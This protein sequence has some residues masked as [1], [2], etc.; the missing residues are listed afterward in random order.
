MTYATYGVMQSSDFNDR[1]NT[2]NGYWGTGSGN[3]GYG[4]SE[5][6]SV[7]PNG[8]L[9]ATSFWNSLVT[10]MSTVASHQGTTLSSMLPVPTSQSTILFL[11]NIDTNQT[12]LN[13]NRLNAAAQASTV[14]STATSTSTWS[15]SMTVT[16]TVTFASQNAVRYYF[17]AG[18][19]I[20][21][22]FSHPNTTGINTL[23]SDLC[24]EAGTVWISSPVSGT[25]SL[26]SVNYN[27]VTKVG[28]VTS[29]RSTVNTNYGFYAFTGTST[30]IFNQL[31]DAG[32]IAYQ[33]GTFLRISASSNGS[34]ILT[35]ACLFDEVPNGLAVST[36]TESTLTRRP[37]SATF[38][39]N[40]W[41]T[42]TVSSSISYL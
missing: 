39:S 8:V 3:A 15:N 25:V 38:L 42:P 17:N 28:G 24:S 7:S 35:F 11:S 10:N 2:F 20:G 13:N 16:F 23:V 33:A 6:G 22:S 9:T 5:L 31:S 29:A 34:G 18:G 1:R 27:G 12:T 14:A 41:G 36:G 19:Q 21:F 37:P 40:S 32:P 26:A 30:Q 4:Q